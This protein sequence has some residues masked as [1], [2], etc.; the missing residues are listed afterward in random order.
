M[1]KK[2]SK[3]NL[4]GKGDHPI[5]LNERQSQKLIRQLQNLALQ[6]VLL[7]LGEDA[8]HLRRTSSLTYREALQQLIQMLTTRSQSPSDLLL[9]LTPPAQSDTIAIDPASVAALD[10]WLAI[11]LHKRIALDFLKTHA[12]K[13][14]SHYAIALMV[15]LRQREPGGDL[16][17]DYTRREFLLIRARLVGIAAAWMEV[18]GAE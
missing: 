12:E 16:K 9:N 8:E 6:R 2:S 4:N 10:S 5:H 1:T 14:L 3:N 18:M 13:L 7:K 15:L 11:D 17:D